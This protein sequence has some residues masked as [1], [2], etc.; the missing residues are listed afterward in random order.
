MGRQQRGHL[1]PPRARRRLDVVPPYLSRLVIDAAVRGEGDAAQHVCLAAAH[2]CHSHGGQADAGRWR[3]PRPGVG[4]VGSGG[5]GRREVGLH[6]GDDV[7][8]AVTA[9]EDVEAQSAGGVLEGGDLVV[10]DRGGHGDAGVNVGR[11]DDV[12]VPDL[13]AG[14]AVRLP[15]PQEEHAVGR[16]VELAVEPGGSGARSPE[17]DRGAELPLGGDL[18]LGLGDRS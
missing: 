3:G 12:V 11:G 4:R 2:L 10:G 14:A 18:S 16:L 6:R 8:C 15:E 1:L 13:A 9:P 17:R 5:V 7:P